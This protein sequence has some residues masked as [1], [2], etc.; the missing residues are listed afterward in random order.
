MSSV[1][2][3]WDLVCEREGLKATL[4]AAPMV[5]YLV[6]QFILVID[7]LVEWESNRIREGDIYVYIYTYV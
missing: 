7:R 5:G 6:G 4:G 1:S 2:R 3:D